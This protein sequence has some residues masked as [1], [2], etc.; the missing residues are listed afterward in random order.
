MVAPVNNKYIRLQCK[1]VKKHVKWELIFL[2][3]AKGGL[4]RGGSAD[5]GQRPDLQL[6]DPN[7]Q[8]H[9]QEWAP[10]DL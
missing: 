10:L 4:T 8:L 3:S 7:I 6:V 2:F 1:V 9:Q 5:W